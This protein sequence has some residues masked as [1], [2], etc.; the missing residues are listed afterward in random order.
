MALELVTVPCLKDNFAFLLH[1]AASGETVLIDA[2]EA[3]PILAALRARGWRLTRIL[4]TH[5]HAD[6]IQAVPELRAATGWIVA[7]ILIS[8][9]SADSTVL[10]S[11]NC[12]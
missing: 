2:P 4:L 9:P 10:S 1:D 3:A 12:S 6:H 11:V 8:V 5:H 7:T